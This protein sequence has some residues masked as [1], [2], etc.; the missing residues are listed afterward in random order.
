MQSDASK[1]LPIFQPTFIIFASSIPDIC[2]NSEGFDEAEP[3]VLEL[4]EELSVELNELSEELEFSV[5][6]ALSVELE[7]PA[8]SVCEEPEFP[9]EPT[10]SVG[11]EP[12]FPEEFSITAPFEHPAR[13][14]TAVISKNNFR[15]KNNTS[16][17]SI[18]KY[19]TIFCAVCQSKKLNKSKKVD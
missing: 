16:Y 10:F 9:E 17:L 15:F 1:E 8:L 5:E 19:F 13:H 14:A 7:E 18:W 4:T 12:E 2:D 3:E 6:L 11:E